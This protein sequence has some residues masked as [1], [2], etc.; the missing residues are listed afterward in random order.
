MPRHVGFIPDGNRRWAE[1]RGMPRRDGYAAGIAPGLA[2]LH[3]CLELG[4]QEVSIYGFTKENARRPADQVK[5]FG[6]AC[7]EFGLQAVKE[8]AALQV[9]GDATSKCFPDALKPYARKRSPGDMRVNLLVNYGWQWDLA[10]G[11]RQHN[12]HGITPGALPRLLASRHA[13]RIDLVVRWGGR[14][15]LSGFLPAQCAYADFYIIDTLWPD[16]RAEEFIAALRWYA[17]QDV[18]LGG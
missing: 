16:M 1:A 3:L 14:R 18:T 17:Q 15:R 5:A 11:V 9:I 12:G 2:L 10:S 6:E 4:I 8:G 7:A 13:G